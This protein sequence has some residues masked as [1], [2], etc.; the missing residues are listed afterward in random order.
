MARYRSLIA[1]LA[2]SGLLTMLSVAAALASP[3]KPPI[4]G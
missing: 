2:L 1:S 3:S 4:P